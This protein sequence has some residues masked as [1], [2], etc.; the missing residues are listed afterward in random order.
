MGTCQRVLGTCPAWVTKGLPPTSFSA[1]PEPA[2][3]FQ[4]SWRSPDGLGRPP[5]R[6]IPQMKHGGRPPSAAAAAAAATA[7]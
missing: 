7:D 2:W 4:W 6:Q 3:C 5:Q 1:L